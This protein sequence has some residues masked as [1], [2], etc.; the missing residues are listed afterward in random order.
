M[1]VMTS[2]TLF[3][4]VIGFLLFQCR[5]D[6]LLSQPGCLNTLEQQTAKTSA[7]NST[8]A[9]RRREICSQTAFC[10]HRK[11]VCHCFVSSLA[12]AVNEMRSAQKEAHTGDETNSGELCSC[13]AGE[14]RGDK[15]DHRLDMWLKRSAGF[16]LR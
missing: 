16:L 12:V 6:N 13:W 14:A 1:S 2:L 9:V 5:Y 8:S 10:S 15:W 11:T 4:S 3:A 7:P